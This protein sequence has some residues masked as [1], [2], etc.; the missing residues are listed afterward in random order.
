MGL[1]S[2]LTA[3]RR[4][5]WRSIALQSC[6]S[7]RRLLRL[8]NPAG[9]KSISPPPTW[10]SEDQPGYRHQ[11]RTEENG[12]VKGQRQNSPR[13]W[14]TEVRCLLRCCLFHRL[15]SY[16]GPN[17]HAHVDAHR[18]TCASASMQMGLIPPSSL[19]PTAAQQSDSS[20]HMF[21]LIQTSED[22][23]LTGCTCTCTC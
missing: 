2:H 12:Q 23:T 22:R 13:G 5:Y 15:E 14:R 3:R 11:R 17:G 18:C 6:Q 9:V 7:P 1:F 16:N 20:T 8:R 19:T 10:G 21:H 4:F